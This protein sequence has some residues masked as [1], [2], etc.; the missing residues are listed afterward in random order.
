MTNFLH[1]AG[2]A[3][4]DGGTWTIGLKTTGAI[5]EA[6]AETAWHAGWTA[7]WGAAG[8]TALFSTGVTMTAL[9]TSTA[10]ATWRQTTDTRDVVAFAGAAVTQELP[11][12]LGIVV[13]SYS[14]MAT[15]FGHGRFFFPAPVSA[16]LS[17]GT[18]GRLSAGSGVTLA[19]AFKLWYQAI[20]AAGLTGLL[21]TERPTITG[22]AQY[23]TRQ[24]TTWTMSKKLVI[25]K[26]RSDKIIGARVAIYP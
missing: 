10:S 17:I 11:P 18:G 19:A 24:I 12:Q 21:E 20:V 9:S 13:S 7:F 1:T 4:S 26:R 5:S 14:A 25:Q 6:A 22:A 23:S 2:G 16:A 3:L 15:K 8:V